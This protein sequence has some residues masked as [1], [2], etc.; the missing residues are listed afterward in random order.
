MTTATAGAA[1]RR[2]W[3]ATA[4]ARI[5]RD[6]IADAT[7]MFIG[8]APFALVIGVQIAAG[9][10]VLGGLSGSLLL[11][12]GSA[13]ASALTLFG[14]GA[15]FAAMLATILLINSRFL[16][17]SAA[18]APHFGGQPRWF[19]LLAP[20]F[21]IDQTFA[22]VSLRDDLRTPARFR[23]YWLTVG[24]TIGLVWVSA[25]TA[26]VLL[27]PSVPESP[28]LAFMPV[29]VFV[30]LLVPSLANRPSVAAAVAGGAAAMAPVGSGVRVLV[31]TSVGAAAGLLAEWGTKR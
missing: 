20:H 5:D 8:V 10:Q 31:G 6:A 21:V 22:L 16:V 14:Q 4:L 15:S 13:Q 18:L 30:G 17:Y 24:I 11:Y 7:P 1:Y 9:T 19:R 25:M 29:A 2:G 23:R 12:A 27:G 26:G 3:A 28:A